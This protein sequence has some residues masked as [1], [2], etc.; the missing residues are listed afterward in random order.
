MNRLLILFFSIMLYATSVFA[1]ETYFNNHPTMWKDPEILIWT[2]DA[3]PPIDPKEFCLS[4]RRNNTGIGEPKCRLFGEWERDSIAIRYANWLKTNME[5]RLEPEYLRA[6]HP[7]MKAKLQELEDKIVLF[8]ASNGNKISVAIFDETATEPKSAGNIF[9]HGDKIALGDE[10][11]NDFF[12]GKTKRRLTKDERKKMQ[13]APDELYQEVPKFVSWV[14]VGAGYS[15]AK[16][17]LTPDNWYRRHIN[18]RVRNYRITRDSVSLWNFLDDKGPVFS[19]YAG[20]TWYGFIGLEIMYRF[21]QHDVKT[22][23]KDTVYRELDYWKFYQ[24]EI[25][26]SVLLSRTYPTFK[27]LDIT[28]FAFL[29]FQYSFFVED[30]GL[31][32]GIDKPS[33]AYG[34]RVEFEDAYKG[35]LVGIGSQFVFKKHYGIGLRTGISSR[36]RNVY[37]DPT[38]DAAAEPTTIG[39]STIDWFVSGGL[40][41]HWAL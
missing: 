12:N 26:L 31:K 16:I 14:G 30:I 23:N 10:I 3:E 33:R 25:G 2:P 35:A 9:Q 39:A 29:G 11:A 20:G 5:T 4:L 6:R 41:Y 21:A 34:V 40:E 15:Q 17:P 24:H 22:D 19:L 38:P 27:W 37:S 18:S 36:G 13:S 8:L 28:P 1:G 7:A 32:E